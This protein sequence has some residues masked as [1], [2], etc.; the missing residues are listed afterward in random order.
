MVPSVLVT[1]AAGFVGKAVAAEVDRRGWVLRRASRGTSPGMVAV[2]DIDASTDWSAAVEGCEAIV[3]LAAR[4][5]MTG[6]AEAADAAAFHVTNCLATLKLAEDATRAGVK[7]LVFVSTVKVNGE[8]RATSYTQRDTPEPIGAYAESKWAAERG[9]A[10]IAARTGLEVVILRPPLVYGAGVGGNFR[11]LIELVLSGIPVP[12]ASVRNARSL[13]GVRNFAS[14]IGAAI[15]HPAAAGKTYLVSDQRDL[16][17]PELIRSIAQ[18]A[19]VPARLFPFPPGLLRLA[20]MAIGREQAFQQ[21]AGSL[22]V[23]SSAISR[24]LGWRPVVSVE[25]ELKSAVTALPRG[26]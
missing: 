14:A 17:T 20:S 8:G 2:G 24:D 7:R 16:S 23:D 6:R 3:H 10:E 13:V 22:T 5:H 21:L 12:L 19:D 1:G 9:L 18:A 26:R 4:V 25:E 11:S 15:E